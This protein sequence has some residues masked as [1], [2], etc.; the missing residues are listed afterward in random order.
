MLRT[1]PC[2]LLVLVSLSGCADGLGRGH[3]ETE[4]RYWELVT[5]LEWEGEAEPILLELGPHCSWLEHRGGELTLRRGWGDPSPDGHILGRT[6]S[7]DLP[8][9][10]TTGGRYDWWFGD[11]TVP[12][13]VGGGVELVHLTWDGHAPVLDGE[14]GRDGWNRTVAYEHEGLAVR[15]TLSCGTTACCR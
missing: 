6:W 8:E 4:A 13:T 1:A 5:S 9:G 3:L 12:G 10:F 11:G 15:E 7:G 14:P 2:I